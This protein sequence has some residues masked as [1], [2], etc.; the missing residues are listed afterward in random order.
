MLKH[1]SFP[2]AVV[3][4]ADAWDPTTNAVRF[5]AGALVDL[6]T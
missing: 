3:N 4:E 5:V 2:A 6:I 1:N